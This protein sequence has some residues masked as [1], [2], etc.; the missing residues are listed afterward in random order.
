MNDPS[1][2]HKKV[3]EFVLVIYL[4][5]N[6]IPNQSE[7]LQ[8]I[9]ELITKCTEIILWERQQKAFKKVKAADG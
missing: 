7:M 8:P 2:N 5:K 6:H 4:V 1:K 3:K 9:T